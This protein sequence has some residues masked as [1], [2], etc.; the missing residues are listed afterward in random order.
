M[1]RDLNKARTE[2]VRLLVKDVHDDVDEQSENSLRNQL[3][4]LED[5]WQQVERQLDDLIRDEPSA[6]SILKP[7]PFFPHV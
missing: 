1:E 5:R 7:L 6:V 2:R 3:E 4:K